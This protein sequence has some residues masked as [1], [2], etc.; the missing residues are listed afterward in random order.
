MPKG[1][2]AWNKKE[3]VTIKC[4]A[5]NKLFEVCPYRKDTAKYCSIKCLGKKDKKGKENP[6]YKGGE[7]KN[8]AGYVYILKP[9]HPF[10]NNR[11]Y[12]RRSHLVMEQKLGRYLKPEEIVHHRNG[13]RDDDRPENL[14]LFANNDKHMSF[15]D[16]KR[17]KLTGRY[18]KESKP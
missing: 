9:D 13:I 1:R 6:N 7:R 14:K 15:H 11:G 5:C 18:E 10:C 16:T 8:T 3:K 12:V 4:N 2:V 17:D